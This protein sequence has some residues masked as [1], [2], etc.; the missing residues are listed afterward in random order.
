MPFSVF[1]ESCSFFISKRRIK[2]GRKGEERRKNERK[3]K[4][5]MGEREEGKKSIDVYYTIFYNSKKLE[6]T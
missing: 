5:Q 2:K 6:V 1:S 4:R 3:K